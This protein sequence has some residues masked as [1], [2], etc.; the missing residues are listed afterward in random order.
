MYRMSWY[1]AILIAIYTV[2][3]GI[4]RIAMPLSLVFLLRALEDSDSDMA[5]VWAGMMM[6]RALYLG[7]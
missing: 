6:I 3:E 5:Y 7:F 1:Y 4:I 2:V